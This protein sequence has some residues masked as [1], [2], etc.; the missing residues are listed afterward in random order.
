[1]AILATIME[2]LLLDKHPLLHRHNLE[3]SLQKIE[4]ETFQ[5]QKL[6]SLPHKMP[7]LMLIE[8][9]DIM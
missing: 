6:L 8:Q 4:I 2:R 9:L 5:Q 1:M 3:I 7:I